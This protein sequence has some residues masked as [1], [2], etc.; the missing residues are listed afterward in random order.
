VSLT[1]R[2]IGASVS[3]SGLDFDRGATTPVLLQSFLPLVVSP[4]LPRTVTLSVEARGLANGTLL[5]ADLVG[6]AA[7]R[8]V[9]ISG[10]P[11]RSYVGQVPGGK[12]V[13]GVFTDWNGTSA[14]PSRVANGDVD[15]ERYVAEGANGTLSVYA[16]V[17]GTSLGGAAILTARTHPTPGPSSAPSAGGVPARRVGDDVFRFLFDDDATG[18]GVRVGGMVADTVLEI[19]GRNGRVRSVEGFSWQLGWWTPIG[20]ARAVASGDELEASLAFAGIDLGGAPYVVEARDWRGAGDLTTV[21]GVRGTRSSG[22]GT[23]FLRRYEATLPRSADGIVTFVAPGQASVSWTLPEFRV[24]HAHVETQLAQPGAFVG[25]LADSGA[26]YRRS[27]AGIDAEIAY[28]AEA[29]RLKESITLFAPPIVG[30]EDVLV[31]QTPIVAHDGL[32]ADILGVPTP[33]GLLLDGDLVLTDGR[34]R[35]VVML[36][37]WAEDAYGRRVDL[38]F[39][40]SD[41]ALAVLVPGSWLAG[42][43][44]PVLVDPTTTYQFENDGPSQDV[45]ENLGYTTALGD[46]NN[47]GYAD[48]LTGAPVN[49]LDGNL[50]GYAYVFYGPLDAA[51]ATPDVRIR[52]TATN[53][54]H[55]WSVA[56]GKFNADG[57][58]D[59]LVASRS[60]DGAFTGNVSIYYGSSSWSGLEQTPDVNFTWP[61]VPKNFGNSVAAANIDNA[62]YDDVLIGE[63]GRDNDGGTLTSDG[64]VHA[65]MSPFSSPET[66]ADFTLKPSTNTNGQFGSSIAVAKIDSDASADVLVGEPFASS[67]N[68]RV[69]FFKGSNMTSGSG[70]RL[71]DAVLSAQTSGEKFGFAVAAGTIDGDA[72]SDVLVGSPGKTVG[73]TA[74][75]G[76][77]YVFLANSDGSGL[78]TGASPTATLSNQSSGEQFGSAVLVVDFDDDGSGGAFV[79]G[80]FSDTGGTDRGAAYW[81]DAPS[82]DQTVD[83][84][85]SGTQN[86]ELMGWSL[87]GARFGSDARTRVAIG[88]YRWDDNSANPSDNDGR[89]LIAEVPEPASLLVFAGIFVGLCVLS[90]KRRGLVRNR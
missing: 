33:S 88:A 25:T 74:N 10:S 48:L 2:A 13:D 23:T 18:E 12:I 29:S 79:G 61:S 31:I 84:T 71:P 52:G 89:V 49:N 80:P 46:F 60:L 21:D 27:Y 53:A 3:V 59:A 35:S 41:D 17:R 42:A 50:H 51:D 66:T 47:D 67:N 6:I 54:R 11:V 14:D 28:E 75:T 20:T 44:Y 37:P 70:D 62:G 87:A 1:F 81:F 64:V 82:S 73:G 56:A 58:W 65:F 36:R 26:T 16:D 9:V 40:W 63:P 57:F 7:N 39:R 34:G 15:I 5:T 8:S 90:L 32:F 76:G 78:T 69:H 24:I 85:V 19:R 43:E 22:G 4:G 45:G 83:E 86:S 77:A 68:G 30:V 38:Q 72:Y 55:G